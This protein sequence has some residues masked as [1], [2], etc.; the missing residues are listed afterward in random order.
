[1]WGHDFRPDYLFIRRALDELGAPS[2][3]GMTATATP[4]DADAIAEALGRRLE[5]VRT[6]VDRPN[7]RYDVERAG[8]AEER[9]RALL[10]RLR[11][12]GRR[13]A[14][15]ST[16]ARAGARARRS[17]ARSAATGSGP[18][19]TTPVSR[20]DERTRVQD[21]FVTGRLPV[22]VATT[23]FG[24]GIDKA[25]V[26]LVA[27]VNL[28]DSLESYVQMVGRAGRD[29]APS[30][31]V[32]LASDADATALR[33]FALGGV[34]TADELRAVYRAIRDDRRHDRAG[35]ARGRG[36][37]PHD[38]RVLVGH[39]RAGRHRAPRLRRGASDADRAAPGRRRRGRRARRR[40]SRAMRAR[41]PR[42]SSGSSRSPRATAAATSRSP[43]T[44]ARRSPSR[45]APATSA[46]RAPGRA[47]APHARRAARRSGARDRRRRRAASTGR[48]AGGAS[49][50]CSAARSPR[51][52][53]PAASPR[54]ASLAAASDAEVGRWVRALEAA[55]ALVEIETRRLPGAPGASRTSTLPA[56]GG[57]RAAAGG[58]SEPLV[59]RAPRLAARAVARGR[60][61]RLRRP[62]RRDAPRAGRVATALDGASS[63]RSRASARPSSSATATSC[64]PCLARRL[65]HGRTG[66]QSGA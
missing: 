40:S 23:A 58:E 20:P 29:G 17:P 26:R 47:A 22:V 57:R 36:R 33:R 27:L 31:T 8:N 54:S 55:G 59:E 45:A 28:P 41:R 64:S 1:M 12:I 34:P 24:M 16:R 51:R 35:S 60:R 2:V 4:A 66:L 56:L 13:L 5:V 14:R 50:R 21:D 37:R 25:D 62:A 63:P 15:S 61:A 49:S 46:P 30:D 65:K 38:P 18:S 48:S 7:L 44:S 32:L 42:G 39:A 11:A 9:L 53:R 10:R 43:S 3:L 52:R 19:T 6:S